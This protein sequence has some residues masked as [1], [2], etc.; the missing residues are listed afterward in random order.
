MLESAFTLFNVENPL[1]TGR[2][3]YA[4]PAPS[5]HF[6]TPGQELR[7]QLGRYYIGEQLQAVLQAIPSRTVGIIRASVQF[8]EHTWFVLA[9]EVEVPGEVPVQVDNTIP[10]F[11]RG[12]D[13]ADLMTCAFF[14]T[15]LAPEAFNSIEIPFHLRALLWKNKFDIGM[16]EKVVKPNCLGLILRPF[17]VLVLDNAN[18][19]HFFVLTNAKTYKLGPVHAARSVGVQRMPDHVEGLPEKSV[20]IVGLGSAG[21][22][23]A[24]SLARMGLGSFFLVDYDVFLPENVER[25]ELDWGSVGEH[26]VDAVREQLRRV[27]SNVQVEVSQIHLTGQESNAAVAEAIAQLSGCDLLIDATANPDVFNVLAAVAATARKPIVWLQVFGGGTG[28]LIARS[29]PGRDPEARRIRQAYIDYC[30]EH[31][32]PD[33]VAVG[34]YAVEDAEG[35]VETASDAEVS[36]IAANAARLAVDSVLARDPSAYA[37]SLYLI[38]LEPWWVFTQAMETVPIRTDHLSP[39][40]VPEEPPAIKD[41]KIQALISALIDNANTDANPSPS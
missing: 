11:L 21:S 25:N 34:S 14:K 30:L 36:I 7:F 41:E 22:K 2:A 12:V 37:Y 4:N 40:V 6:L 35:R 39:E 20:G 26:K 1:G 19:D 31:P 15:D 38:G 9:H 8:R 29:R 16:L 13:D 10:P 17:G 18:G 24:V 3:E 32:A 33:G 27:N 28:G 5:R 23:I